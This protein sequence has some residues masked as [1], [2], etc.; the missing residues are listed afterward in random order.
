MPDPGF[1]LHL[2]QHRVR[3]LPAS[4]QRAMQT[5][6]C[7]HRTLRQRNAAGRAG[8][9]RLRQHGPRQHGLSQRQRQGMG[10]ALLQHAKYLTQAQ[11]GAAL[12]FGQQGI[13]QAGFLQLLP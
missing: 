5:A 6:I 11:T 13:G 8:H 3:D 7:L 10:S 1:L 9:I 4:H 2:H 12:F